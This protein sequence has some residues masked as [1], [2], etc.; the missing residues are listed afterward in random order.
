MEGF[1][2]EIILF[3]VFAY[4]AF[5]VVVGIWAMRKTSNAHDFFVAGRSLGPMVVALAVFSSTLSGFGFVGGPGLV[6]STGA[7]SIWMVSVSALGYAFGFFLVAKRIRM[8]A[9]LRNTM[10]LPDVVAA[11]YQSEAAR[12][13]TALTIL[14]GVMGYLATQI[15]AMS[16]ILKA[17]L[18][19]TAMFAD[20]SL[21]SCVLIS[22]SVLIFYCVTGGII[23]S[24]YTDVVQG[25]IMIVAGV[26]IVITASSVFDGGLAQASQIILA[27]NPQAAMPF[28]TMGLIACL[29]WFFV[30]GMGLAGQPHLI[31]KMMMNR[32]IEDNRTILPLSVGGYVMAALLW[33]SVGIVMRALV[34]DGQLAPLTTADMAAPQFLAQF[35]HPILAGLVFAGL[36]AAIMS[37]SDAFLNIG[38]AAIVHDIPVGIRGRALRDELFWARTATV[39]LSLLAAAFA[40]Y[41]YYVND[42]MVALLGAFGWATFAAAI[43]PVVVI[44]L[45]WRGA[46][47]T[48]AITAIVASLAI[49]LGIELFGIK[50]P[51]GIHGGLVAMLSSMILF[52]GVSLLS[53]PEKLDA[54]MEK[55]LAI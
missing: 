21:I 39:G 6:Y 29:S 52:I 4:M 24:V 18:S 8:V 43:V 22:S 46:T 42:Q 38:A 10:S 7:S 16:L 26:L 9:E 33:I 27:D 34:V 45:N 15:L 36:F 11:R 31:T 50:L 3:S 23:A 14:L 49:N 37:T 40:L 28:G 12:I 2:Q 55:V 41:S 51:H 53:K 5:C 25:S 48:G 13:L 1:R 30:F 32:R 35:A 17:L 54:D 19:G 20:I 44:G 47:S